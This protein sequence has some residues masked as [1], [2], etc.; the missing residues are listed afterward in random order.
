[1]G[2]AEVEATDATGLD[3]VGGLLEM[4]EMSMPLRA[5]SLPTNV[6][7]KSRICDSFFVASGPV[8]VSVA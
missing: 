4:A 7:T 1:M 5:R 8:Y 3:G 6:L 2:V